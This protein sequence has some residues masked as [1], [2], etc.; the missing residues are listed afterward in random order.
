MGARRRSNR[1]G[2]TAAAKKDLINHIASQVIVG[3]HSED[4]R[5]EGQEEEAREKGRSSS[6]KRETFEALRPTMLDYILL[7]TCSQTHPLCI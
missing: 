2:P 1:K 4:R 7:I 3:W 5:K 6:K